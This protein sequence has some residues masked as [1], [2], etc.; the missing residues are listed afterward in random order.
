MGPSLQVV[1]RRVG[2]KFGIFD[3]LIKYI[4]SMIEIPRPLPIVADEIRRHLQ[5]DFRDLQI[6]PLHFY[7]YLLYDNAI[8]RLLRRGQSENSYISSS[9]WGYLQWKTI[10]LGLPENLIG[11]T[12]P[13]P[14]NL[15][16][17]YGHPEYIWKVAPHTPVT[18]LRRHL[19][20]AHMTRN[21]LPVVKSTNDTELC[22]NFLLFIHGEHLPSDPNHGN[23]DGK[24]KLISV[25]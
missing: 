13:S 18:H 16:L 5:F 21:S 4:Y 3:E 23:R 12:T 1:I 20:H 6:R 7:P 15:I 8:W 2:Q 9:G 11:F 25:D 17:E 14:T 24:S 10:L 22:G 19:T